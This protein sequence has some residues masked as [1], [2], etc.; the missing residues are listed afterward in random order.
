MTDGKDL[1]AVVK[2]DDAVAQQAPPLPGMIDDD[3]GCQMIGRLPSRAVRLML[4]YCP[5]LCEYR[6]WAP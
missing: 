5:L 1:A 2:Q 6:L 3:A 4:T